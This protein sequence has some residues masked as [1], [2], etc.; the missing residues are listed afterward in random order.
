MPEQVAVQEAGPAST[1]FEERH[2][3]A[4]EA[5]R[6]T[7]EKHRLAGGGVR[8]G[9]M[10]DMGVNEIRRRQPET[11]APRA[12]MKRRCDVEFEALCPH[13]VV[14]ILAVEADD[15]LPYGEPLRLA[16]DIT[17][18]GDRPVHQGAQHCNLVAE[19]F[20]GKLQLL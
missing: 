9:E 10:A 14:I 11:R 8:G 13:R 20:D 6:H 7:A 19:L 5:A 17:G 3:K 1:T 12:G 2:V 16:L 4:G 18:R 15:V